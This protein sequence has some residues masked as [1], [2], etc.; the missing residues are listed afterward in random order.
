MIL[1]YPD[2]AEVL[3]VSIKDT[4]PAELIK[5]VNAIVEKYL[6]EVVQKARDDRFDQEEKL[7]K[8]YSDYQIEYKRQAEALNN[9]EKTERAGTSES[10]KM[11]KEMARDQLADAIQM[12]LRTD[13]DIQETETDIALLQARGRHVGHAGAP[14]RD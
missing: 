11:E 12:R 5:I 13:R 2:D 3:R 8:R 1:D 14:G 6:S 7:E 10:A 4:Q 9:L